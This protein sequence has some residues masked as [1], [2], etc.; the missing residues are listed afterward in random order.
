[1]VKIKI[2][3]IFTVVIL[4]LGDIIYN[5]SL[6]HYGFLSY[7]ISFFFSFY[8]NKEIKERMNSVQLYLYFNC[9]CTCYCIVTMNVGESFLCQEVIIEHEDK[10]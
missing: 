2:I 1:M 9:I 5:I 7:F 8:K 6:V 10:I 4:R 3:Y